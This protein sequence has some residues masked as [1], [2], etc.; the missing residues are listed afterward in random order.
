MIYGSSYDRMMDPFGGEGFY[1]EE[2]RDLK[3]AVEEA[4]NF[5]CPAL[6]SVVISAR[7]PQSSAGN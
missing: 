5:R 4:I 1:V 2:P 6:V 7:K 3:G